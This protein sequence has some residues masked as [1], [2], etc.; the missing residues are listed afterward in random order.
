MNN[1][2]EYALNTSPTQSN[3]SPITYTLEDVGNGEKYL[4]LSFPRNPD[5]TN[6]N[7]TVQASNDAQTWSDIA[8]NTAATKVRDIVPISTNPRRFLRLKVQ[9][10]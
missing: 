3:A 10:K 4:T 8:S 6:L 1:L 7:Y 2:L 5:A 9:P